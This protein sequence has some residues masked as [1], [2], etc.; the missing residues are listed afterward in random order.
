MNYSILYP[1]LCIFQLS[2]Y[3]KNGTLYTNLYYTSQIHEVILKIKVK[4]LKWITCNE[5]MLY[6]QNTNLLN[7]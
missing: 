6:T 3:T 7:E 2:L 4:L 5:C 1:Q